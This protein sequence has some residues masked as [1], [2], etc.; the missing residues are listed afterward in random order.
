MIRDRM[1]IKTGKVID[2]NERLMAVV[3]WPAK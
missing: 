3:V 2:I 1:T